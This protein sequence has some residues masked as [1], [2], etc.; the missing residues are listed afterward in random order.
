MKQAK[1]IELLEQATGLSLDE[2]SLKGLIDG[3]LEKLLTAVEP[4]QVSLGAELPGGGLGISKYLGDVRRLGMGQAPRHLEAGE[5]VS[6]SAPAMKQMEAPQAK[7]LREGATTAGGYLVPSEQAGEVLNLVNNFSAIKS[8][9]RQVPMAGRQITFP[10]ISGG[11]TAYWVPEATDTETYGLGDGVAHGEKPPSEAT[12]GQLAL[13]SHVLA[14]KVVVSNQ[15]LD[16]SDP[17]V[18][19]V[20]QNLFAETIGQAFDVACLRGTGAATDPITG[21]AGKISTNALGVSGS[22]SF[23]DLAGLIFAVYQNAPHAASVPVLGHP[24]AEKVLMTLKDDNG[25]YIYRHPG[26]PRAE[27]EGKP[28][29]WGEP[30]VRDPNILTNLGSETNQTRL[31][32]GDFAGSALVGQRQG[33]VVKTNPWAEPYFSYNQTAFLAEVRIGF[34]LSDEKRFAMLSAVPTA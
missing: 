16:D 23:D 1:I 7:D 30:F 4:R 25:D 10:T 26:Q 29:V 9:C 32:S 33:L 6:L 34:N 3:R 19:Q 12:F 13:T 17:G 22:L 28:L 5:L 8:L 14:V 20:L 11:L 15:L 2:E 31:F 21:L 27:G 24:K 18:D